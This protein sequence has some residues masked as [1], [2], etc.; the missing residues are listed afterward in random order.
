[1]NEYLEENQL[2]S[3]TQFGFRARFST[4]DAL[5][6]ATETIRKILD[7]GENVAVA[8]LDLSKAFDSISHE[9]LLNKLK[10]Y[11]CDLMSISMIRSFFPKDTKK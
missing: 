8:F 11:N 5:L 1:M 9:I 10:Q 2:L 7:D 4:I 6:Y 3:E